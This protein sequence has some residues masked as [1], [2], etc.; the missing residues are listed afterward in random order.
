[1]SGKDNKKINII[2][3]KTKINLILIF[4]LYVNNKY[5][6]YLHITFLKLIHT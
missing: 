3:I 5:I 1:M 6:K 2:R 4:E